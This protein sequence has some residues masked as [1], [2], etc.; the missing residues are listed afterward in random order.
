M[1]TV[2]PYTLPTKGQYLLKAIT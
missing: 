2:D 1:D